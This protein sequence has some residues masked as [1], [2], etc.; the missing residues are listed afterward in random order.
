MQSLRHLCLYSTV[1]CEGDIEYRLNTYSV[2]LETF[3]DSLVEDINEA[4]YN[5]DLIP[6]IQPRCPTGNCLWPQFT[7]LGFCSSCQ[8]VT[9]EMQQD[10]TS[11]RSLL[12]YASGH[13]GEE[14]WGQQN[15]TFTYSVPRSLLNGYGIEADSSNPDSA[16]LTTS[17]FTVSVTNS[18]Q[19]AL[20]GVP[21]LLAWALSSGGQADTNRTPI[22][23]G[24]YT[25]IRTSTSPSSPG[26]V[27]SADLCSMSFCLQNRSVSVSSGKLNSSILN[28]IYA[29]RNLST[30]SDSTR[31]YV[32][33]TADDNFTLN[34]G[35][36][37]EPA[38]EVALDTLLTGNV[39]ETTAS[40][41]Q[42]D[43]STSS[44]TLIA[45]FDASHN[46]SLAMTNLA[47]AMTN[48]I[49][50]ASNHTVSGQLGI[51]ETYVRVL[52]LWIILPGVI[53][54]AGALFLI[55]GIVETKKR[56]V[57]VWKDSELALL[58]HGLNEEN[59]RFA[60]LYKISEMDY[61]ASRIK[62]RMMGTRNGGR[63]L[64]LTG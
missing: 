28:T 34:L 51:T 2:T 3:N 7:S 46:F 59:E 60:G 26:S 6:D 43:N 25:F 58:F 1:C 38:L 12:F 47:A 22:G 49:R 56:G 36:A 54:V 4:V 8:D 63:A 20:Q 10:S 41:A 52:W 40:Q 24:L 50:D 27:L 18:Q 14:G 45:G 44:S 35:P 53:V 37:T 9:Q 55:I 33:P 42:D 17:T 16:N 30:H 19:T 15:V 48:Y 61:V 13:Q 39:S 32:F 23:F 57:E 29:D 11:V 21:R 31:S 62:V 5:P 64:R